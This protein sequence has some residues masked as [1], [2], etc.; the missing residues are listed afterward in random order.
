M[1]S[2]NRLA[3]RARPADLRDVM[4]GRRKS[5]GG[6]RGAR[7]GGS[8]QPAP[9]IAAVSAFVTRREASFD[10]AQ[11]P[12]DTRLVSA[13]PMALGNRYGLWGPA[14]AMRLGGVTWPTLD[15]YVALLFGLATALTYG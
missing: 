10:C 2:R 3:A 11:L 6:S 1:G 14:V 12:P 15:R 9:P 7:P 13:S 4:G 8:V 5:R